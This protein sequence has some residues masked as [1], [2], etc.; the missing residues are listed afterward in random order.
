[1]KSVSVIVA[2]KNR[3]SGRVVNFLESFLI[4]DYPNKELIFI[5]QG[6]NDE[7]SNYIEALLYDKPQVR[8]IYNNTQG[9]LW[10]KSNALNIGIKN[11]SSEYI[12]ILDIDLILPKNYITNLFLQIKDGLF[13]TPN[14]FYLDKDYETNLGD[15]TFG[16]IPEKAIENFIGIC[17]VKREILESIRGY[18][19]FYT[20]WGAEDDDII[21]RLQLFGLNRKIVSAFDLPSFHQ[22]HKVLAPRDPNHWYLEMVQY[23]FS[24]NSVI[25][26]I[27]SWGQIVVKG[28]RY[29][30]NNEIVFHDESKI[31]IEYSPSLLIF[32]VFIEMFYS[33]TIN[34]GSVT[35]KIPLVM[36][37]GKK[38]SFFKNKSVENKEGF[39]I[40]YNFLTFFIAKN[41][42]LLLDYDFHFTEN[43]LFFSYIKTKDEK[44][45]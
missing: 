1:L 32:N 43:E 30:Y 34:S 33:E 17:L 24:N 40:C 23:L 3:E 35:I 8:Y 37:E 7:I 42:Q 44:S 12:L 16:N 45:T 2:F 39:E 18:D 14:A 20:V 6:S 13:I 28:N 15:L 9:H 22:W 25:R 31:I 21:K 4:Q 41:R 27:E 26:N 5:N 10:N 36:Q 19:E 11:S 29:F 38:Y